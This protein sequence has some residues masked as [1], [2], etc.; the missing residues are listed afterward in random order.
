MIRYLQDNKSWIDIAKMCSIV[1]VVLQHVRGYVYMSDYFFYSVWWVV[2]LFVMIGG[3]NSLV[4][5][6][7]RG[8]FLIRKKLLGIF[9]PYFFA[10]AIYSLYKN[11][12]WDAEE[13]LNAL[14]HFNATGPMYYVAVYMQLIAI[15]PV[16]I[17]AIYLCEKKHKLLRF[18]C[19]WLVI[20]LICYFTTHFTNVF[21]III[22]GGNLFAGP[23]L[24]FWFLGM[25]IRYIG[26]KVSISYAVQTTVVV[27]LTVAIAVWQYVFVNRGLNL[28]LYSIFHGS[29]LKMTWANAFE[30][31]MIFFWF[32]GAV[33]LFVYVTGK[34]GQKILMPFVFLGKHTLYTF[35]YHMLFLSIYNSY[36]EMPGGGYNRFM[37]LA[38]IIVGPVFLG[39]IFNVVKREFCKMLENVKVE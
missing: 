25:F 3:Y 17:G 18:P 28:S 15:T 7:N 32:M 20:L 35:L 29:Q 21:D 13:F 19:L 5:Y 36:L 39:L 12:F 9:I 26:N 8:S 33:E 24:F 23:W 30:T 10:T 11:R 27:L 14:L 31:V 38:F 22:G 1:G 6:E 2:A 4:S 37:C 16:L 34:I